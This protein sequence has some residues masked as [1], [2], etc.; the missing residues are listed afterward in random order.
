MSDKLPPEK[1]GSVEENIQDGQ[2]DQRNKAPTKI[3]GTAVFRSPYSV[4]SKTGSCSPYYIMTAATPI[5]NVV[6]PNASDEDKRRIIH[7]ETERKRKDKINKWI[8]RLCALVPDCNG[9]L[10]KNCILEKTVNFIEQLKQEKD[11]PDDVQLLKTEVIKLTK[12][13]ESLSSENSHYLQLLKEAQQLS[14]GAWSLNM[15]IHKNRN[16][17]S[18]SSGSDGE[19]TTMTPTL[20]RVAVSNLTKAN[21]VPNLP[22]IVTAVTTTQKSQNIITV[23]LMAAGSIPAVPGQPTMLAS[24]PIQVKLQ[25]QTGAVASNN[26]GS[27]VTAFPTFP[28]NLLPTTAQSNA[29]H[30]TIVAANGHPVLTNA[31]PILTN[32]HPLLTNAHPVLTNAHPVLTNAHPLLTNAHPILTN[33]HP[34]LANVQ[35]K[36]GHM[37]KNNVNGSAHSIQALLGAAAEN[38]TS[39]VNTVNKTLLSLPAYVQAAVAGESGKSNTLYMATTNTQLV[40]ASPNTPVL[41]QTPVLVQGENGPVVIMIPGSL[42]HFAV[43]LNTLSSNQ[44]MCESTFHYKSPIVLNQFPSLMNYATDNSGNQTTQSAPLQIGSLIQGPQGQH[45]VVVGTQPVLAQLPTQGSPNVL[46]G[47]FPVVQ[48]AGQTVTAQTV[49]VGVQGG[50][51][52][53]ATVPMVGVQQGGMVGVQQGGMVGVQNGGMVGVQHGG[54]VGVQQGGMVGV[55]A[56]TPLLQVVSGVTTNSEGTV[57][58]PQSTVTVAN[59]TAQC[60]IPVVEQ[61]NVMPVTVTPVS[62]VPHPSASNVTMT[63]Q[64]SRNTNVTD[65]SI[66]QICQPYNGMQEE[67]DEDSKHSMMDSSAGDIYLTSTSD[68]SF[69]SDSCFTPPYSSSNVM[70]SS[71]SYRDG[72]MSPEPEPADSKPLNHSIASLTGI[73]N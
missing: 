31:H 41:P 27:V 43:P 18:Q 46:P 9:K 73:N 65:F 11:L 4:S 36:N 72:T 7:N 34:V 21:S 35:V 53:A 28:T 67:G 42:P 37:M 69:S 33:A 47:T 22:T 2:R 58:I 12:N 14:K 63:T 38:T 30:T 52:Q 15:S 55:Q 60:F 62:N 25:T 40:A 59:Q 5:S 26:M 6:T 19:D 16:E 24:Q 3:P 44:V 23:P 17:R 20:D 51:G 68:T 13:V 10:S 1:K 48:S 61:T 32:G 64:A 66:S 71:A 56:T 45:S 29:V 54:M 49:T 50:L 57:L 39:T 70:L 8:V